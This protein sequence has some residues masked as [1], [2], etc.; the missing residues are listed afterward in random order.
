M[1][2]SID[3]Y[4]FAYHK[5]YINK[6]IRSAFALL[7]YDDISYKNDECASFGI[8]KDEY[9]DKY[10]RVWFG[11]SLNENPNPDEGYYVITY[12]SYLENI[13]GEPLFD[14]DEIQDIISVLYS[15]ESYF[16]SLLV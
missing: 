7:G 4:A 5:T 10:I 3:Y 13:Q 11:S 9:Q 2:E 6:S 15:N 8:S 14:S 1:K 12:E 16:D